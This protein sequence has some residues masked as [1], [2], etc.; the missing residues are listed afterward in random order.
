MSSEPDTIDVLHVDDD[1]NF[2]DLTVT[3]LEREYEELSLTNSASASDGLS[4]LADSS[5]DCIVSD[6]EM[7]GQNGIEF[8]EA[9]REENPELPFILFTGKG[10]E[11]IA[12]DAISAGATDYI[13]KS[14]DASQYTVLTNRIK[15]AVDQYRTKQQMERANRRRRRTL[16]R[17]TDGFAELDSDLTFTDVNEQALE[18]TGRTR[19]EIIGM[20]YD[21]LVPD[22]ESSEF[23]DAYREV[24]ESGTP[25][26]VVA[27]SDVV[28]DHW[29]EERIFPAEDE[30]GIFAYFQDI[31]ERKQREQELEEQ[32]Q[33]Y[34]TLVDQSPNG[35]MIVQ[36]KE[37]AFVNQAM[38]TMTGWSE[39]ELL[40]R[41][42]YEV[43]AEEYRDL[44]KQRYEERVRG[45]QPPRNYELEIR[46]K[47]GGRRIIDLHVSQIQYD[48]RP[49]TLATFNDVTDFKERERTLSA[50][51]DAATEIS[52]AEQPGDVY[53][54]LIETAKRVLDFAFVVV[55]V[56]H[57]G[58]LVQ[59]AWALDHEDGGYY[60]ETSLEDD[61]T[62]AVRAYNRQETILVDDLRE[63]DITPADSEYRAALSVPIG[64]HGTFQAG[65]TDVG[66]FGEHDMEFTELL[67][68]HARVKLD[69]IHGT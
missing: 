23:I 51:H 20:T 5:F 25:Q 11:E 8:L 29:I 56:E 35:V 60:Y 62:F 50:L 26:T 4:K 27:P 40:G 1:S 6:Y 2:L 21:E 15:N 69:Q 32:R 64:E 31:T 38:A 47:E 16:R 13:Q 3:V 54:T 63:Y 65:S 49:A 22:P 42:F 55:D 68:D 53:E 39:T 19:E 14:G 46:T 61:D 37:I 12:A 28:S 18:M 30:H 58:S 7:P 44:A 48:G 17:I 67:V 45:K 66:A 57:D 36:D 33:L 52:L 10:S 34:S 41:S 24:L 59:E 9:V 43:L